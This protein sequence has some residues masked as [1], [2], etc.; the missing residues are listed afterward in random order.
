MVTTGVCE[1]LDSTQ[2]EG[3]NTWEVCAPLDLTCPGLE[4]PGRI[5]SYVFTTVRTLVAHWLE[6]QAFDWKVVGLK[7]DRANVSA[8]IAPVV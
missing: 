7:L 6:C 2:C 4:E 8:G 3:K 1:P 5:V